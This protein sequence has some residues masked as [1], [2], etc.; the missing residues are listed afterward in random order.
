MAGSDRKPDSLPTIRP[1][2]WLLISGTIILLVLA[3]VT[4]T[5]SA[6]PNESLRYL[7]GKVISLF[8]AEFGVALLVAYFISVTIDVRVRQAELAMRQREDRERE[9][10]RVAEAKEIEDRR[11]TEAEENERR[12]TQISQNVVQGVYG[13][14]HTPAYV[15]A[16][17]ETSLRPDIVRDSADLEYTVREL[18]R[19][20]VAVT[21]VD[22]QRFVVLEMLSSYRFRNVASSE[23][24]VDV[25]YAVA[26]R[27]GKGART[28]TAVKRTSIGGTDL[29]EDQI[30][31]ALTLDEHE[32]EK[33]YVWPRKIPGNGTL[34]VR[35]TVFALKERS[36]NE[37]WGSFFPTVAGAT[38]RLTVLPG[39]R[40]GVRPLTASP[41]TCERR[42]ATLG[43]WK[44]GG[45]ILPNDSVVFWWRTPEDDAE[46]ILP[47]PDPSDVPRLA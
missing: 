30:V 39:M 12:Q 3:L 29:T 25:R 9:E 28:F 41:M 38:L 23:K 26:V 11:R 20:E 13:L 31:A 8:V 6:T 1:H 46:T 37:V 21:G 36:D 15:K 17:I 45:S 19:D 43:V 22:P 32:H 44:C 27:H 5:T 34:A 42:E 16:V 10:R 7:A 24:P 40:F 4:V 2:A 18:T 33:S 35:I 47:A 14:Q